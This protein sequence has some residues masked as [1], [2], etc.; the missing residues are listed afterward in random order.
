[1]GVRTCSRVARSARDEAVRQAAKTSMRCPGAGPNIHSTERWNA[2]S[3]PACASR[4]LPEA[5][6]K[7]SMN[8]VK[9]LKSR[10]RARCSASL[11][12]G[13]SHLHPVEQIANSSSKTV[14]NPHSHKKTPAALVQDEL[15]GGCRADSQ[16]LLQLYRRNSHLLASTRTRQ[17]DAQPAVLTYCMC[18]ARGGRQA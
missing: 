17:Q 4:Q 11:P 14:R 5:R 10:V 2:S 16:Q 8:Y 13:R 9:C 3:F 12:C 1:M 15:C 7:F 6:S 18:T